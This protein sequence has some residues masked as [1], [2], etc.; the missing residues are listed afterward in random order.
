MVFAD[1]KMLALIHHWQ[2]HGAHRRDQPT[3]FKA[4]LLFLK[5]YCEWGIEIKRDRVNPI[6]Y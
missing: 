5:F 2:I 3:G 4:L 6:I 1:I